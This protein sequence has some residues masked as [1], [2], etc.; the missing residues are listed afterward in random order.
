ML[1]FVVA[2]LTRKA[3]PLE[4][5]QATAFVGAAPSGKPQ[6]FRLWRAST[7]TGELEATVARYLGAERARRAFETF[8][9]ER[10]L[11]LTPAK[12]PTRI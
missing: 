10:G 5:M 1:A 12:R 8:Q 9:R 11:D 7:T 3:T 2:S 6:A 4:R